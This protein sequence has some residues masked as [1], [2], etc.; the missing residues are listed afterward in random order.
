MI[1]GDE[2]LEMGAEQIMIV[3]T[4]KK[5][6]DFREEEEDEEATTDQPLVD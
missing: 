1:V 6:I 2:T 3:E 4:N 5:I